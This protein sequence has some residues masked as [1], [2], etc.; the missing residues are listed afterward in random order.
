MLNDDLL[1]NQWNSKSGVILPIYQ[2]LP[3]TIFLFPSTNSNRSK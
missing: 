1:L 2:I 3:R